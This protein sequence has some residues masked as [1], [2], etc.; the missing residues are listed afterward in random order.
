MLKKL[1][2]RTAD[3]PPSDD[4]S[5]AELLDWASIDFL[6][7][8][9][10]SV[11]WCFETPGKWSLLDSRDMLGWLCQ[12]AVPLFEARVYLFYI[13]DRMLYSK[14]A[15][16]SARQA[17]N[18]DCVR[19]IASNLFQLSPIDD[20]MVATL[21]PIIDARLSD[22]HS[23]AR[24]GSGSPLEPLVLGGRVVNNVRLGVG[25]QRPEIATPLIMEDF[26]RLPELTVASVQI[27]ERVAA[28]FILAIDRKFKR[29]A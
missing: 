9:Q 15:P 1:F 21:D 26:S 24:A 29:T 7:V 22:Y 23:I 2:G 8:M 5:F 18:L 3:S 25:R 20:S 14:K 13:L 28:P 11:P 16:D 12:N 6:K 17:A 19:M 10:A 4:R 27:A